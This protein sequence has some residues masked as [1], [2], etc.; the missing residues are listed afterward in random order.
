[1]ASRPSCFEG[2]RIELIERIMS[3]LDN[4][5]QSI[6]VLHGV[7]GIGKSTVSKSVAE[8]AAAT[9]ALGAS[10]FF[11]RNEETRKTARSLFPTL[12]YQLSSHN[13]EFAR[14]LKMS[15]Q[16]DRGAAGRDLQRQFSSLISR[17]FQSLAA[18]RDPILLVIDALDECEKQDGAA[19]LAILAREIY[20]LRQLKVLI[21]TRPERHI[22]NA[23]AEY[24]NHEEFCLQDIEQSVVE[25]DIRLYL[26]SRLSKEAVQRALPELAP[27]PWQPTPDQMDALVC[28]SGKLFIIASTAAAFVLDGI[29]LAPKEQLDILLSGLS[30]K[31]FSGSRHTFLDDM[32]MQ[33][34]RAACPEQMGSWVNRFQMI[35]GTVTLLQDPL[36]CDALAS[37]L[38]IDANDIVRTLSNLHALFAPGAKDQI[39]RIHHKSFPDFITDPDRRER[40]CEFYI[41]RSA[42]HLQIAKHCLIIMIGQLKHCK[43]HEQSEDCMLS[44]H[45]VYA[46]TYWASHLVWGTELDGIL[47]PDDDIWQL[48]EWFASQCT[49]AWLSVLCGIRGI[50]SRHTYFRTCDLVVSSVFV[51]SGEQYSEVFT[52]TVWYRTTVFNA[53]QHLMTGC[54]VLTTL[55]TVFFV[56]LTFW[57]GPMTLT[58]VLRP[59]NR[60]SISPRI[61]TLTSLYVSVASESPSEIGFIV[62]AILPMSMRQSRLSSRLSTSPQMVTPTNRHI[63]ITSEGPSKVGLGV[64]ATL[65]M[66]MRQS[67]LSSM[68]SVSFQ[69]VTL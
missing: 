20:Q 50:G 14:Q 49:W 27:P 9:G 34:I 30:S 53:W 15:L 8:R 58:C 19:V 28:M 59:G 38:G 29:Q 41:D 11:S 6:Y 46:C 26:D 12:A 51:L 4:G 13:R 36:S 5:R 3:W 22:R 55:Q 64:L 1:M 16:D 42:H 31:D 35:V 65:P 57:I 61:I 62:L 60:P 56:C 37:L 17:P 68:P 21:T 2:T 18:E 24:K 32:Y 67:R 43:R 47:S 7:A 40:S 39:F 66:P 45:L 48:L 63:S 69:M 44:S 23:L 25:A 52:K 54:C 10:F 33:I